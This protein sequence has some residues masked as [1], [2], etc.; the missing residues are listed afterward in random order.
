M[1]TLV[2]KVENCHFWCVPFAHPSKPI[3]LPN[4]Q[5]TRFSDKTDW[6]M[7]LLFTST[8]LC[9]LL[10]VKIVMLNHYKQHDHKIPMKSILFVTKVTN[11]L[12][13]MIDFVFQVQK[14]PQKKNRKKKT[15]TDIIKFQWPHRKL[16]LKYN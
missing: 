10:I 7:V 11:G 14:Y 6:Q 15:F 4:Q 16:P 8:G 5:F 2:L 12:P 13:L 9:S 3:F 1:Y